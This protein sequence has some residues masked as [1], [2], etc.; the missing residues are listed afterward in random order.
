MITA[1]KN[2]MLVCVLAIS[3]SNMTIAQDAMS[4]FAPAEAKITESARMMSQGA[5]NALSVELPG[6]DEKTAENVWKDF[7]KSWKGKTK[8]DRKTK[9]YFTDNA[10]IRSISSNTVDVYATF[11]KTGNSTTA[12]VWFD[13]GGAYLSSEAHKEAYIAAEQ[14]M[15]EY[16][17][18]VNRVHAEDYQAAQEKALK[19]LEK[20]MK[21][22]QKDNEDYHKK[23]EDA[24]KLIAEMEKNIEQNLKSQEDKRKEIENQEKVVNEAKQTVKNFK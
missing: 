15:R 17:K 23:I 3:I 11:N 16:V 24:K 6:T 5:K 2:L 12:T 22:L 18:Q 10:E 8:K 9:E 7:S 20:E 4:A 19:N 14:L 13:L 21:S 1:M